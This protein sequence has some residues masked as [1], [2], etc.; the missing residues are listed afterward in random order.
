MRIILIISFVFI[1]LFGYSQRNYLYGVVS[2]S[3]TSEAMIGVHISNPQAGL[4]TNTN[5]NGTFKIPVQAGDTLVLS[6]VGY[7]TTT[8]AIEENQPI[9]LI[10][11]YL[12][13]EA[14]KLTEVEVNVF[15][16][17]WR[18]KQMVV[19]S[20]PVNS[21]HVVFGLAAIPLDAFPLEANELKVEPANYQAPTIGI[22]FNLRGLGK[23]GK[24]KKKLEKILAQK[25]TERA[26][27]RK[28]NRDWVSQETDLTGDELTNFIA[29]CKFTPKYLAETTL[30]EIHGRMMA[31]LD[32]FKDGQ[33]KSK[34]QNYNPGA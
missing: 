12:T 5:A 21:T 34:N 11:F 17:Y 18:F 30:F 6:Y 13:Q 2:D 9:E 25:E 19:D 31:L 16:E 4:L 29:F 10:N 24:E 8:Y 23:K 20:Q 32:E 14:T 15:P 3:G 27:Y 26:A 1:S 33:N 7:K 28:F 22:G